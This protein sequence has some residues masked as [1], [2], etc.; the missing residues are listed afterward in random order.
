MID[1]SDLPS[2]STP[3]KISAIPPIAITTAPIRKPIAT[4]DSSP[5]LTSSPKSSGPMMPPRPVPT[6]KKKA[7]ESAR[8]SIGKI[9]ETVR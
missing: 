4:F 7:I 8:L 5:V 6:A 2:A 1:S 9:S 3:K